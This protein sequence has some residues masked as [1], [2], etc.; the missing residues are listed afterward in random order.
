MLSE[1]AWGL[2][3]QKPFQRRTGDKPQSRHS[4]PAGEGGWEE[5]PLMCLEGASQP[6]P[7]PGDKSL[8]ISQ[9][10]GTG[11]VSRGPRPWQ[12]TQCDRRDGDVTPQAPGSLIWMS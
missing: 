1:P 3:Q 7:G 10:P 8:S 9:E 12:P 11:A 5:R 2:E 6:L 4:D